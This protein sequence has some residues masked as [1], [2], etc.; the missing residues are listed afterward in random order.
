MAGARRD[1]MSMADPLAASMDAGALPQDDGVLPYL[2][3]PQEH[4]RY[5]PV[6][7]ADR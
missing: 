7:A 5:Q 6:D 2:L 4:H 3:S 1:T